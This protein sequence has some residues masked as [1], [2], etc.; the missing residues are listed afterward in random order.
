MRSHLFIVDIILLL[1]ILNY[2]RINEIHNKAHS[3]YISL[4]IS[5]SIL[6]SRQSHRHYARNRYHYHVVRRSPVTNFVIAP[7]ER[8]TRPIIFPP[9]RD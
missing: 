9:P 7:A 5:M 2:N 1:Y 8:D 3:I 4:D 6:P